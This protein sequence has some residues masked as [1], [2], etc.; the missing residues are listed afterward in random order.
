MLTRHGWLI[1]ILA[2]GFVIGGRVLG[3]WELYVLGAGAG[4]L[5]VAAA[6]HIGLTRLKLQV[7]RRVRPPRVHARQPT[8]VD[9]SI[10]NLGRRTPVLRLRDP[11]ASTR[12]ADLSVGPLYSGETARAAYRVPTERRGVIAIGPMTVEVGDPFGLAIVSVRAAGAT[13]LTVFPHVDKIDAP[14]YTMGHDPH[15]GAH[16]PNNLG[17]LGEDFYALRQYTVG[18]DLRRVHWPTTARRDELIVRQDELPWQ[19]RATVLLDAR[20]TSTTPDAFELAVSAAASVLTASALRRDLTRMVTTDGGDSGYAGGT[21]HT[22]ALMEY[23]ASCEPSGRG[24]LAGALTILRRGATGGMLVAV[25][26]DLP[27][28]EI[29]AIGALEGPYGSVTIVNFEPSSYDPKAPAEAPPSARG[30][31]S[32][33]R[34]TASTTFPQ[35]WRTA[36]AARKLR[37]G[38]RTGAL[39]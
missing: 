4:A 5:V 18:D 23:L 10:K 31:G 29:N 8:R 12:G 17:R 39:R 32:V 30:R 26:T 1:G 36:V 7:G 25:G 28:A 24:S 3:V 16:N 2:V 37:R 33:V 19:G 14:P 6:L 34:V 9:I 27:A 38:A 15:G 22:D 35:A 11:V 13:E 20:R 21:A